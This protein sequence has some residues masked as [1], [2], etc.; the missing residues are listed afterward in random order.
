[1]LGWQNGDAPLLQRGLDWFNP[2]TEYI[3]SL[4]Q[5]VERYTDNVEVFNGSSPLGCTYPCITSGYEPVES[6]MET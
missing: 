5:L 1:M 4:A 3:A 2:N 6:V